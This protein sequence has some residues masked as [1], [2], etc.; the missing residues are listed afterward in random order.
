LAPLSA[1][2]SCE[3]V[4]RLWHGVD[5]Q[6]AAECHRATGGNPFLL[7][8]LARELSAAGEGEPAEIVGA[9]VSRIDRTVARRLNACGADADTVAEAVA[10][11]GGAA[12]AGDVASLAGL[13]DSAV[14]NASD[15]LR[16]AG[17]FAQQAG[18]MTFAHPLVRSAVLRAVPPGR[19]STRHLAAARHLHVRDGPSERVPAHLMNVEPGSDAWVR[20]RLV[21]AAEAAL[22]AGAPRSAIAL[23]ERALAERAES[24]ADASLR[25][26]LGRAA[27]RVDPVLATAQLRRAYDS[28][29]ELGDRVGLALDLAVGYQTTQRVADAVELLDA[30]SAELRAADAPRAWTLR[31]EA[32]L[33]AQAFFDPNAR[34][35]RTQ[36]LGNAVA[37]LDGTE[38]AER[39]IIVQQGIQ[40]AHYGTASRTRELAERAWGDGDLRHVAGSLETPA[41]MWVPYLRMYVDD[42]G[43]TIDLMHEWLREAARTGSPILAALA[44]GVL[45]DAFWRGGALA[46]AE[47]A[48]HAGWAVARDIGPQFPG[49]WI[50]LAALIQAQIARG[51]PETALA[52]LRDH[53]LADGPPPEIMLVPLMRAVRAEAKLATGATREAAHELT[54][55]WEWIEREGAPSPG[56]W[57]FPGTLVDALLALDQHSDARDVAR[58][59]LSRTRAFGTRS[60]F[61][62]AQRALGLATGGRDGLELLAAAESTLAASTA[63]VEHARAQLELGAALR[64]ANRRRDSREPLRK[65]L[66]TATRLGAAT[67]AERARTELQAAGARP[68]RTLLSGADALTPSERRVAQLAANG[69]T[70]REIAA[71]LFVTRKTVERHLG[72]TYLKL[73]TNHRDQ[74]GPLLNNTQLDA[75]AGS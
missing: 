69:L 6:W 20:G 24:P 45:S 33:L 65:A 17:L 28:T 35:L 44:H 61:G 32:E 63:R 74:L 73:G 19:A 66:D 53:D 52:T 9:Q 59:W 8:E 13:P 27:L 12:T 4:R 50:S 1:G 5:S 62:I 68:R 30:L 56:C 48:A 40:E 18:T 15:A 22:N 21:E 37:T 70:N 51:E 75:P 31:I 11:L 38:P 2:A 41:L 49:W 39:L 29:S 7:T 67:L 72:Q 36:R 46:D 25:A 10:I 64:R 14:L 47:A 54:A 3:L 43:W 55:T 34:R 57:R 42:V 26:S 23:L 16:A 71:A 60:T 58:T